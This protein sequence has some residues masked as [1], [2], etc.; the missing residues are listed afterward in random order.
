MATMSCDLQISLI[1]YTMKEVFVGKDAL[2]YLMTDM[3]PVIILQAQY[4]GVNYL[5]YLT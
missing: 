3:Y 2:A 4:R 5:R 1:G